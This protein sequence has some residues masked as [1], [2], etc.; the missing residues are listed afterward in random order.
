MKKMLLLFGLCGALSADFALEFDFDGFKNSFYYKSDQAAKL[1]IYDGT[2]RSYL[3]RVGKKSYMLQYAAKKAYYVDMDEMRALMSAQSESPYSGDLH[4]IENI[5]KPK[6]LKRGK[7]INFA[8]VKAEEWIVEENDLMSGERRKISMVLSNQKDLVEAMEKFS[9]M[10]N[11]LNSDGG[12]D[13]MS[14]EGYYVI[15]SEGMKL[16]SFSKE[17]IDEEK[18]LIPKDAL[19]S[20]MATIGKMM[21]VDEK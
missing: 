6:V 20:D 17:S 1:E 14:I 12:F 3:Y 9:E 15:A 21:M 5:T 16:L 18:L 8:G 10:L 7:K 4:E 19:K 13:A 11:L 2:N